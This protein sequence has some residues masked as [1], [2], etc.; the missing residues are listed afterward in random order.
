MISL[1]LVLSVIGLL[2]ALSSF[3][4]ARKDRSTLGAKEL[5]N[6]LTA[7]ETSQFTQEDRQTL[8]DLELKMGLFWGIV[9]KE[10]PRL[11]VQE[12]TPALDVLLMKAYHAGIGAFTVTECQ[13]LLDKLDYEY[14]QA[15]ENEDSGRAMAISLFRA[16]LV[17]RKERDN[18][19]C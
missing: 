11:L 19:T 18:T 3:Y 10:F 13:D 8:T 12:N 4:Y 1:E 17:Y 16:T 5:E 9:E 2:I 7:I 14:I 15:I 6:R